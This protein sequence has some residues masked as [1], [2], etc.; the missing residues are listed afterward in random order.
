MLLALYVFIRGIILLIRNGNPLGYGLLSLFVVAQFSYPHCYPVYCLLLSV[1]IGAAGSLD[2]GETKTG[3]S[4]VP[5]IF[6]SIDMLLLGAVL[7]L[8][9]PQIE[10]KNALEKK[11]KDIAFFFRNQEYSAVCD[12]CEELG[13]MRMFSL[14]LL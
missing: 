9:L 13:D 8:E 5:W 4:C 11:E 6:N 7:F 10:Q 3:F 1:F 2:I 12:Y 14:N